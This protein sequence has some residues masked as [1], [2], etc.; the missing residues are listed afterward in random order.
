MDYDYGCGCGCGCGCIY[1]VFQSACA[2]LTFFLAV[3]SLKGGLIIIEDIFF[4]GF[5]PFG[6]IART[7]RTGTTALETRLRGP[8]I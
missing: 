5:L 3:S 8:S 2:S 1:F 7:K 4:F 6:S